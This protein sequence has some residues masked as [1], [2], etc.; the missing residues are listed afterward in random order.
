[1]IPL[2]RI[3]TG[4]PIHTNFF[5]QKRF[6]RNLR[7]LKEKRDGVLEAGGEKK[8]DSG[9]WKQSKKQL[10]KETFGKCAYCETPTTVVVYGDV[11]HFRPKSRYWWLAYSYENYLPSCSI[12]NQKFK[13][14]FFEIEDTTKM[15]EGP[16]IL[17]TMTDAELEAL[18][19]TITVDPINNA[20][21]MPL[22]TFTKLHKDEKA[23]ILNPYYDD[24]SIYLAY[25]PILQN[26]EI[27]VKPTRPE[28]QAVVKACEKLYGV[29]RKELKTHRF[30][31]YAKYMTFRH[32][33]AALTAALPGTQVWQMNRN[34]LD[35]MTDGSSPYTGMVRYLDTIELKDLP[36][37]FNI[38][39]KP[40]IP[41]D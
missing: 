34:R 25:E 37:D 14:D 40:L 31:W 33:L 7:L 10:L 17:A 1:M 18:A 9:F 30:Q 11:E 3:R 15:M 41:E 32:T 27:L 12:C 24:P 13:K 38:K 16:K 6:D 23:L 4:P 5:G 28:F 35:E 21:G 8:W 36:W 2:T 26:Q 39:V 19:A 22:Q 20:A 29:N